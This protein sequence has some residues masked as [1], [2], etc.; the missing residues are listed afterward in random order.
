MPCRL[1]GRAL[2]TYRTTRFVAPLDLSVAVADTAG[3]EILI[4]TPVTHRLIEAASRRSAEPPGQPSATRAYLRLGV[5]GCAGSADRHTLDDP[6]SLV[7]RLS[8]PA[9]AP[10]LS[11][12]CGTHGLSAVLTSP[13]RLSAYGTLDALEDPAVTGSAVCVPILDPGCA[14][15]RLSTFVATPYF[16]HGRIGHAS[17]A[18]F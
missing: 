7:D 17:P 2:R 1:I 6:V 16:L 14:S 10:V 4:S 11:P 9:A 12:A 18:N 3:L 5:V 8:A 15:H 13:G